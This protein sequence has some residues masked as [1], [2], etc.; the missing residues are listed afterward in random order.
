MTASE[1]SIAKNFYVVSYWETDGR[2]G[3]LFVP[4][5]R[6]VKCPGTRL[7]SSIWSWYKRDTSQSM[8]LFT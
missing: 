3:V 1:T 7:S 6:E 8:F 5:I 4:D 2:K